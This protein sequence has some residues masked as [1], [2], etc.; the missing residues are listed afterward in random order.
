MQILNILTRLTGKDF[1]AVAKLPHPPTEGLHFE[2]LNL[3]DT[4]IHESDPRAVASY[5]ADASACCTNQM[6]AIS[7]TLSRNV[8]PQTDVEW[9][10]DEENHLAEMVKKFMSPGGRIAWGDMSSYLQSMDENTRK[11]HSTHLGRDR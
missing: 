6:D 2:L 4:P 10:I 7:E 11:F 1:G 3:S 9:T 5:D 8:A